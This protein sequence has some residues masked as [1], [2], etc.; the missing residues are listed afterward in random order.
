MKKMERTL[1][2]AGYRTVN[3][4]YPSTQFPIETLAQQI[5]DEIESHVTE[6]DKVHFVTHSMGGILVRYLNDHL[7]FS[8][9]GRVVMLCPPNQ[10]SEI[11]DRLGG[12]KLFEWLNGPAGLQLGTAKDGIVSTLGP[13]EFELGVIA[14]DRSIDWILSTMIPGP[15]DGKVSIESAR[16]SGMSDYKV[17]HATH[18]YIM[19]NKAVIKEVLTFLETGKFSR[20]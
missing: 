19:K 3:I 20:I 5:L 13:V 1:T 8:R 2:V 4:D 12:L 7:Q 14:G 15:N 6:N 9:T 10:G 11:V 16:I 17:A 18:P